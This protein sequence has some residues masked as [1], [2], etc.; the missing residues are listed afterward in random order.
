MLT[1]RENF[2]RYFKDEPTEWMPSGLDYLQFAPEEIVENVVRGFVS[3][4]EPFPKEK[5]GGRGWFGIDWVFVPVAGGSMEVAPLFENII[6]WEDKVE[7]PNLD[8]V[9]WEA[10]KERNKDYLRT[11]KLIRTSIFT[12]FYERLISFVGFENAAVA[13]VDE[14]QA[15]HVHRLFDRLADFY[16]DF[17]QRMHRHCNVELFELHDDWG[18]QKSLMFSSETH[19]DMIVPY[20]RKV[21]DAAHKEG[22]FIEMHSCGAVEPL[23]P[24][25]LE[26][27]F[28]TWR[29]QAT[30]IDKRALVEKYGDRFKFGVEIRP[31]PDASVK[32]IKEL[33][34]KFKE[35]YAGKKV[36]LSISA[37]M[38]E[39]Q[40][41][42]IMKENYGN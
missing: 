28:D 15:E 27:G 20:V 18:T 39:Y 26:A 31:A 40:T 33:C 34:R 2:I 19:R 30:A 25:F 1:P 21:V 16:I 17:I 35:D 12:G 4:Q 7:W 42:V 38:P 13:L 9:D 8:E 37:L 6:G 22:C 10:V 29:G 5:F 32:E 23:F 41:E 24:N 14:D 3:Q 11:D 36:W